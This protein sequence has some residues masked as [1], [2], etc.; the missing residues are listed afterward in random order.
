MNPN[1]IKLYESS[2]NKRHIYSHLP[3]RCSDVG[4][5]RMH[6]C[7]NEISGAGD[8]WRSIKLQMISAN[9]ESDALAALI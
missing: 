1:S 3:S 7:F 2:D 5:H 6:I 9:T 4:K 8:L